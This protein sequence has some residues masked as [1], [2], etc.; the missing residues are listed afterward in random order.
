MGPRMVVKC[1][2]CMQV[3]RIERPGPADAWP[4]FRPVTMDWDASP[5]ESVTRFLLGASADST[6]EASSDE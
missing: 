6:E 2:D 3:V 4:P 5:A 1:Q